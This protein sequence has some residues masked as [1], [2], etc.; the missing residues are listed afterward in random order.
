MTQ[1]ITNAITSLIE[2][3]KERVRN[4]FILSF[5]FSLVAFNWKPFFYFILSDMEVHERIIYI[6]TTFEVYVWYPFFAALIYVCCLNFFMSII[7]I[8]NKWI[9]NWRKDNVNYHILQDRERK[10]KITLADLKHEKAKHALENEENDNKIIENLKSEISS[11]TLTIK[12]LNEKVEQLIKDINEQRDSYQQEISEKVDMITRWQKSAQVSYDELEITKE[13]ENALEI[14]IKQSEEQKRELSKLRNRELLK[15]YEI[16]RY[17][18]LYEHFSLISDWIV[19][20]RGNVNDKSVS[21]ESLKNEIKKYIECGFIEH[22]STQAGT[23]V[24]TEKGKLY[25]D[26]HKGVLSLENF[27]MYMGNMSNK[28]NAPMLDLSKVFGGVENII[29]SQDVSNPNSPQ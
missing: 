27:E 14:N 26:I 21:N 11:K 6:E 9:L 12:E 24:F 10:L 28:I 7:D 20:G 13:H 1:T 3:F 19:N 18:S 25:Y 4:P 5:V 29:K 16:F 2:A 23:Y 8:S 17:S 15:G 22:V